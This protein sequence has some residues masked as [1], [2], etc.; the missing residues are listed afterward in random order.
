MSCVSSLC[1]PL[2]WLVFRRAVKIKMAIAPAPD[3]WGVSDTVSVSVPPF[4]TQRAARGVTLCIRPRQS[5]LGYTV[6]LPRH[7]MAAK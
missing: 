3:A 4:S 6:T 5:Q 1:L 7:K 2:A